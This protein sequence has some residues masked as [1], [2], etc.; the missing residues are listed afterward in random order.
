MYESGLL[1]IKQTYVQE[2]LDG[3]F[4]LKYIKE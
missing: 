4:R 1:L 3:I 2:I